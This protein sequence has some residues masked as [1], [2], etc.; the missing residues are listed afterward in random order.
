MTPTPT[1]RH[2][3]HPS[4]RRRYA[5]HPGISAKDLVRALAERP[6]ATVAERGLDEL[7]AAK[8]DVEYA[9]P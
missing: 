7:L 3:T 1:S 5:I 4:T 9:Q 8:G 6:R 2:H